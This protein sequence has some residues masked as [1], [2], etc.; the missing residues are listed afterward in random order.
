MKWRSIMTSDR[1]SFLVLGVGDAFSSRHYSSSIVLEYE[2]QWLLLDCPHPI[3]K[4]MHEA[5]QVA[6]IDLD[7]DRLSS[8][9]VTHL[10]ADHCSGLE[11]LGYYNLFVLGRRA[12]I[13]MHPDVEARLWPGNLSAGM[14]QVIDQGTGTTR[15]MGLE[16]YFEVTRLSTGEPTTIGPFSIECRKT[17]HHI[18]TTAFRIR[19][20]TSSLGYSSDTTYDQ[21]LIDWLAETDLF[22]HETNFGVHTPY[23]RLAALPTDV[24]ARMRL[25]HYPDCFDAETSRIKPLRQGERIVL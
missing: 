13:A 9:L 6:G 4:I 20:G 14:E 15:A 3:R 23:E 22:V 11:G 1:L 8:T 25:I 19:A 10:H 18:P 2:G 5:G 17:V 16:D 24:R 7:V 12:R 21:G